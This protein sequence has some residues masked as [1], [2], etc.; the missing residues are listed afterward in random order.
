MACIVLTQILAIN[1]CRGSSLFH[2]PSRDTSAGITKAQNDGNVVSLR[3]Q[4]INKNY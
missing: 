1:L 2:P 4:N 3:E